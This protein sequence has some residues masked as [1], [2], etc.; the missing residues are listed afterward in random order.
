MLLTE[1]KEIRHLFLGLLNACK[2]QSE[3]ETSAEEDAQFDELAK[4]QASIIPRI[5][6]TMSDRA[7]S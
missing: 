2:I 3:I 5:Y 1:S 4:Y 6:D 7:H